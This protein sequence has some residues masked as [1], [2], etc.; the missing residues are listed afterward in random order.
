MS[1]DD[2]LW[3]VFNGEIYNYVELREELIAQGRRFRTQSDTEVILQAYREYGPDCVTR[4][5][6]QFAFALWDNG[7]AHAVPVAR[8]AG[9]EAALLRRSAGRHLVFGSEMKAVLSH[10]AV[11]REL[12]LKGLDQVFTFWCTRA[13]AHGLRGDPRAA[14]RPLAAAGGRTGRARGRT[15]SS[16]TRRTS[17]S[18]RRPSTPRSC[19]RC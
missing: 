16:T 13:A 10:P 4:F 3:I 2:G 19:G 17:A 12:D 8:P 14:A 7:R 6:G 15:G 18:A 5:N 11:P 1:T 9:Q